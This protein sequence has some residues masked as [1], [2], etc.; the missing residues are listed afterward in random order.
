MF[1]SEIIQTF[2]RIKI[3]V[4]R[5]QELD[6]VFSLCCHHW[7]RWCEAEGVGPALFHYER[8]LRGLRL[9]RL[10]V[11]EGN[12]SEAIDPSHQG[13]DSVEAWCPDLN[14]GP[15]SPSMFLGP[16]LGADVRFPIGIPHEYDAHLVK[17]PH[18][19]AI[20]SISPARRAS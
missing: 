14:E 20:R 19:D 10:I 5:R 1:Y 16:G 13:M 12:F 17:V 11:L 4:H 7:H 2:Y 8:Y 9:L 6:E 15:P 3:P 18:S